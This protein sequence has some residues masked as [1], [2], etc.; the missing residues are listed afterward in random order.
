M[1]NLLVITFSG[2]IIFCDQQNDDFMMCPFYLVNDN[3]NT[4]NIKSD[5]IWFD[6]K[7]IA[8]YLELN[9]KTALSAVKAD[10]RRVHKDFCTSGREVCV[11]VEQNGFNVVD[12]NADFSPDGFYELSEQN[13][14]FVNENGI[15][16]LLR[17]AKSKEKILRFSRRLY[18]FVIPTFSSTINIQSIV[19]AIYGR[20]EVL[21]KIEK[22]KKSI[23][24]L[25]HSF[26]KIRRIISAILKMLETKL[27][28]NDF[29]V[30]EAQRM[31]SDVKKIVSSPT[32]E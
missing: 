16:D 14:V 32:R 26:Y 22:N 24:R 28:V 2:R 4:K 8:E 31:L 10:D 5:N 7:H 27:S 12:L 21:S 6:F 15:Y 17:K 11:Y 3:R 29:V 9:R 18:G 23:V 1:N 20:N 19:N 25:G 30:T 13:D